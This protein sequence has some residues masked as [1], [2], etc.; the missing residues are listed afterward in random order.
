MSRLQRDVLT[1]IE[2]MKRVKKDTHSRTWE[3]FDFLLS[4]WIECL[5]N[6]VE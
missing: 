3:D 6:G 4:C 1:I 5:E 2:D